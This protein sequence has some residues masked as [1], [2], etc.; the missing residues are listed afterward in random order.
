MLTGE[1][2]AETSRCDC[3]VVSPPMI[4]S[5]PVLEDTELTTWE[6]THVQW[7]CPLPTDQTFD[8]NTE[9][10]T[11]PTL[12]DFVREP[13]ELEHTTGTPTTWHRPLKSDAAAALV[14]SHTQENPT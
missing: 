8:E 12:P 5:H 1:L 13:A 6:A 9:G 2:R 3:G 10:W 11:F 14:A 4:T 7:H